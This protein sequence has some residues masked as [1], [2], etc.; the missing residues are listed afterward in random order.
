M[1]KKLFN[2][3]LC[4][5]YIFFNLSDV[6]S[7]DNLQLI[8]VRCNNSLS[9]TVVNTTCSLKTFARNVISFNMETFLKREIKGNHFNIHYEVFTKKNTNYHK[10]YEIKY[11][12]LCKIIKLTGGPFDELKR[13]LDASAPG[14]FVPCPWKVRPSIQKLVC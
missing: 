1:D 8:N 4:V 12:D 5:A 9:K 13:V 11:D 10:L 7:K 14:I 3:L 2:N 6:E